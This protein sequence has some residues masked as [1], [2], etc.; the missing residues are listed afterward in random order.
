MPVDAGRVQQAHD[1]RSPLAGSHAAGEEPV[2]SAERNLSD[3]LRLS[4]Q[5]RRRGQCWHSPRDEV[6]GP[7]ADSDCVDERL[8][9]LDPALQ[10]VGVDAVSYRH[11]GHRNARLLPGLHRLRLEF[12]TVNSP[13][14]ACAAWSMVRTYRQRSLTS[15]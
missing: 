6:H 15:W 11:G 8:R 14:A 4:A 1:G 3:R 5:R 2:R 7:F 9:H 10:Q 12:G 13:A